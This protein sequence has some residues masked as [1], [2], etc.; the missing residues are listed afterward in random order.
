MATPA[1]TSISTGSGSG[2]PNAKVHQPPPRRYPVARSKSRIPCVQFLS[3]GRGTSISKG[4]SS[5]RPTKRI[6]VYF[7][8]G[9]PGLAGYYTPFL[10]TLRGLLD[11]SCPRSQSG[12]AGEGE[13][14]VEFDLYAQNLLGF[15]DS[16]HQVPFGT[17][18]P[19]SENGDGNGQKQESLPFS[20]EDQI[21]GVW[22]SLGEIVKSGLEDAGTAGGVEP[23]TNGDEDNGERQTKPKRY[24]Y[25]QVIL[26][27]HSVGAYIGMEIFHRHH[28]QLLAL[29]HQQTDPD[30]DPENH[31]KEVKFPFNL[32]AG[33]MLF[34]TIWDI[35]KSPNGLVFNR[36]IRN[37]AFMSNNAH[38]IA[39]WTVDWFPSWVLKSVVRNVM[40]FS[41]DGAE[42]TT[43]FLTSRDGIHQALYLARDEMAS[44]TEEKWERE[45]WEASHDL[46]QDESS[47]VGAEGKTKLK[48]GGDRFFFLFGKKDHW[49]ADKTR[50]AFIEKR[51]QEHGDKGRVRVLV[52]ETGGV[53]GEKAGIPHAFCIHHSEVVAEK[54][55]TWIDEV[56]ASL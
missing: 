27:G 8:P 48:Q 38:K 14:Q 41:D 6:L 51:R 3:P 39:K 10:E 23:E 19:G 11:A 32:L 4:G 5:P 16:D 34:P 54:V 40:G 22:D 36:F 26:M 31:Q 53:G 1:V 15:D 55:K 2:T 7:V 33:I 9:N 12:G 25:D 46:E 17:R 49:V 47:K 42:T 21:C 56:V 24:Y 52:D 50:D 43:N 35:A 45:M 18:I 13:A 44:I 29:S 28:H 20:L 30:P 37:N